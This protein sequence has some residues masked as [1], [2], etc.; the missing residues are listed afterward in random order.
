M[1]RKIII[2]SNFKIVYGPEAFLKEIVD[3]FTFSLA[4]T[5]GA[6]HGAGIEYRERE[7]E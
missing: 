4:R 1:I 2:F 6:I 3:K 7:E 5:L